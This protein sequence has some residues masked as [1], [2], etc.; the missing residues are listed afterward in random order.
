VGSLTDLVQQLLQRGQ[1]AGGIRDDIRADE[2]MALLGSACQG[3]LQGGWSPDLRRR[4]L[5]IMFAGL[6]TSEG[7]RGLG[8]G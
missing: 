8:H 1:L 3:A 5:A 7:Q 2:V 4:T 6:T